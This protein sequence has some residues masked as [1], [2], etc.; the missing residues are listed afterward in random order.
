MVQYSSRVSAAWDQNRHCWSV[1]GLL[2]GFMS[3][4]IMTVMLESTAD[5]CCVK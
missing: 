3:V 1:E 5:V 2:W 4:A